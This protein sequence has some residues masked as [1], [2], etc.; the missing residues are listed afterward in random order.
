MHD[1]PTCHAL[2]A[3]AGGVAE[4]GRPADRQAFPTT[5]A[6]VRCSLGHVSAKEA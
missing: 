1:H 3:V 5:D 4:C 2:V 6:Y